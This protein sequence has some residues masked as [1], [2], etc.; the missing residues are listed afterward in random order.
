MQ[1]QRFGEYKPVLKI[2]D[3]KFHHSSEEKELNSELQKLETGDFKA[4]CLDTLLSILTTR[5]HQSFRAHAEEETLE[6]EIKKLKNNP[7]LTIKQVIDELN[8]LAHRLKSNSDLVLSTAGTGSGDGWEQLN[9]WSRQ[10][11]A[12]AQALKNDI[13]L[14]FQ[15]YNEIR[16]KIKTAQQSYIQETERA[17]NSVITALNQQ[18]KQAIDQFFESRIADS[19][20]LLSRMSTALKKRTP[21]VDENY[22]T[23]AQKLFDEYIAYSGKDSAGRD[24]KP[25]PPE[26]KDF[27][28]LRGIMAAH[29]ANVEMVQSLED[30]ESIEKMIEKNAGSSAG[31]SVIRD[32]KEKPTPDSAHLI[33]S[34]EGSKND[35]QSLAKTGGEAT[36]LI[37]SSDPSTTRAAGNPGFFARNPSIPSSAVGATVSGVAVGVLTAVSYGI[38]GDSRYLTA[39]VTWGINAWQASLIAGAIVAIG[40]YLTYQGIKKCTESPRP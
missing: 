25:L 22:H 21:T 18:L 9:T 24:A 11:M 15:P 2:D 23:N 33:T 39:N 30:I 5:K 20:S 4:K 1:L 13:G 35:D 31:V 16:K 37:S 19:K 38:K 29:Q 28:S 14:L 32:E 17:K 27:D 3:F 10:M 12:A 26:Y 40:V 6:V 7:D 36:R 8:S 34:L